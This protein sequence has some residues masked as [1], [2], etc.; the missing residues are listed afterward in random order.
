MGENF[1]LPCTIFGL[2]PHQY[3]LFV[4]LIDD[5]VSFCNGYYGHRALYSAMSLL[6]LYFPCVSLQ[7]VIISNGTT[8]S[9][10]F[11]KTGRYYITVRTTNISSIYSL[12]INGMEKCIDA[13]VSRTIEMHNQLKYSACFSSWIRM[14][15]I[16]C[17]FIQTSQ[18]TMAGDWDVRQ[19][20]TTMV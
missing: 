11:R 19:A 9:Y 3:I 20:Q 15:L 14:E 4:R 6:T 8:V 7:D 2:Q 10:K 17:D 12:H 18:V 1:S 5:K 16:E 13:L